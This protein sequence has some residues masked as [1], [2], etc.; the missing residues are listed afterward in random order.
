MPASFD[1]G[2]HRNVTLLSVTEGDD[3]PAKYPVMFRAA[4]LVVLSK[5]DL[6]EVLDDFDPLRAER[7]CAGS[8][9]ARYLFAQQLDAPLNCD[10]GWTGCAPLAQH[11]AA[12]GEVRARPAAS[13]AATLPRASRAALGS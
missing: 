9:A 12:L 13:I 7:H 1:L 10:P 4:H 3:K 5:T 2:A 8:A 11:R 6:L